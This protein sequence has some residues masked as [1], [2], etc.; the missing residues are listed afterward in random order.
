MA[1]TPSNMLPLGTRLPDVTLPEPGGH[2][3]SVPECQ[4]DKGLLVMFICNHCPFVL[5]IAPFLKQLSTEL[6]ALGI[7]CVAISSNDP[8]T[9]P[10]D[11][12]EKMPGFAEK[13]GFDFPYL[14]DESQDVARIFDA[15]CTPDFYLFDSKQ[16]LVY[17]GQMDG[18]RPGND[19]P[20][21][22]EDLLAA[23][24]ALSRGE[25]P[26]PDQQPSL[27]CNIK[28]KVEA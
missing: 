20:V 18:S 9:Y 6:A 7:Q 14:Y 4:G 8:E 15:A 17:R 12:P 22:G 26:S 5:H 11:A 2:L 3:V 27:G 19:I 1:R 13:Y 10:D 24:R 28:W 21:T 16:K 25:Q 23:G